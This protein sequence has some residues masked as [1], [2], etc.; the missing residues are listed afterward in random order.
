MPITVTR[1]TIKTHPCVIGAPAT[2]PFVT[3]LRGE[4]EIVTPTPPAAANTAARV[5]CTWTPD[6]NNPKVY[7]LA[8]A[9]NP[10][11]H[12]YYLPYDNDK[13]S[14]LRLPSPPPAGVNLFL[15]ANMS[16]CK[17]FVD[18]INGSADLLVYHAN[19]RSTSPAPAHSPVDFQAVPAGNELDRLHAAAQADYTALP[20][21]YGLVNGGSLA[22][23]Q[24][25]GAGALA[26]Q[27]KVASRT[28][29][30]GGNALNPEFW[31]GCSIF[32]FYNGGWRFYYQAW[33]S[34]EYD[35]PDIQGAKA[36]A[37]AVAT[38]HWNHLY[39]LRTQG[40]N[41]GVDISYAAVVD[42]RRFYP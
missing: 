19:A 17:F 31:G 41:K 32:G 24:Y 2:V 34:V 20:Y 7:N 33:G 38:L 37:K 23:P 22:K 18:T 25:Y 9:L 42:Q 15:T 13:I 21:N 12:A 8:M 3:V 11:G 6:Q 29:I 27:R 40:T 16:G 39:K 4:H 26:E 28:L 35:R 14:S 36:K 30:V 1:D 5:D 10:G